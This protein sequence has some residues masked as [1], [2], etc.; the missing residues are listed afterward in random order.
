M[1]YAPS[2]NFRMPP[3]TCICYFLSAPI[4]DVPKT[5]I[6]D[7]LILATTGFCTHH[8]NA[9]FLCSPA[10]FLPHIVCSP[11]SSQSGLSKGQS[12]A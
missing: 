7:C 1:I 5:Y 6:H 8:G 3:L 11:Q 2:E 12:R 9:L 10:F 4:S